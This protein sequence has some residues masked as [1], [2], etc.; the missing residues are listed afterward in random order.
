M[1][2]L[3]QQDDGTYIRSYQPKKDVPHF[4]EWLEALLLRHAAFWSQK[5]NRHTGH[6][7]RCILPY[8]ADNLQ[9]A[10]SMEGGTVGIYCL[11]CG[12]PTPKMDTSRIRIGG[13]IQMAE[14]TPVDE[15]LT[16]STH[17][18]AELRWRQRNVTKTG[19]GCPDCMALYLTE[20]A[21]VE[22]DNDARRAYV[23]C[24]RQVYYNRGDYES[25]AKVA[26][27]RIAV[28][29]LDI[30]SGSVAAVRQLTAMEAAAL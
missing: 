8:T 28:P 1:S 30:M 24:L 22:R 16:Y 14:R 7:E 17:V 2:R 4:Q 25:A 11:G 26:E 18:V 15:W 10:E 27:P 12:K 9:A 6:E 29:Y 13:L 23:T 20:T 3:I 5:R 21:N 19:L